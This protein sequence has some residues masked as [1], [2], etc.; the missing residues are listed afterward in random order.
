MK[1]IIINSKE[2]FIKYAINT[3]NF[4]TY[5]DEDTRQFLTSNFN[6]LSK[7]QIKKIYPSGLV[8]DGEMFIR[9]NTDEIIIEASIRSIYSNINTTLIKGF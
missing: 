8:I 6:Y 1:Y 2:S 7:E 3:G 9:V 4:Y 5:V